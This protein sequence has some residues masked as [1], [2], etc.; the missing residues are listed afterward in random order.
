[1]KE[2]KRLTPKKD[3]LRELYLKSGNQCAYPNCTNVIIDEDGDFLGEVCHIKAA[4]PGGERFDPNQTNDERRSFDNLMLMCPIHHTKTN[5]VEEFPV[6]RLKKIKAKHEANHLE[7]DLDEN[8]DSEELLSLA[9]IVDQIDKDSN[10]EKKLEK[11]LWS[12]EAINDFL[13]EV[14]KLKGLFKETIEKINKSSQN[15][16]LRHESIINDGFR[17]IYKG[18]ELAFIYKAADLRVTPKSSITFKIFRNRHDDY[19]SEEHPRP[20]LIETNEFKFSKDRNDNFIWKSKNDKSRNSKK[21]TDYILKHFIQ[22][23]Q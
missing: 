3:T 11:Y 20:V 6:H 1:M 12:S 16:S 10:Y 7:E 18:N 5:N 13:A 21:L 14:E 19:Y 8:F 23:F 22:F 15:I 17:V 4:M 9:D 2:P